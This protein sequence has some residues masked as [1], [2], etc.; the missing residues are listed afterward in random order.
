MARYVRFRDFDWV[1][2]TFV[3]IICS[4]GIIEI[5]SPPRNTKSEDASLQV[6]QVYWVC[7]GVLL[8]FVVS[9]VNYQVLLDNV[10]WMYGFSVIS[11]VAVMVFG[12]RY[13]GAK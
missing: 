13:L 8:M 9:L 12:R 3:L 5:Y 2:L 1:L 4:L 6:K 7:A 10:H 11:L